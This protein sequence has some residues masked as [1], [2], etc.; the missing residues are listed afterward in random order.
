MSLRVVSGITSNP[1]FL[2]CMFSPSH[3]TGPWRCCNIAAGSCRC[4]QR[5]LWRSRVWA[6]LIPPHSLP[7]H[8]TASRKPAVGLGEREEVIFYIRAVNHSSMLCIFPMVVWPAEQLG[9]CTE[10][11]CVV[12]L[13][14][15]LRDWLGDWDRGLLRYYVAPGV[16][17]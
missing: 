17:I 1:I 4:E 14:P 12:E 6:Y 10:E 16:L 7:A 8:K 2:Q 15:A 11:E 5:G 9:G 13:A 3:K